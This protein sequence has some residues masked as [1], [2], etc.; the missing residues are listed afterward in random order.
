[1]KIISYTKKVTS[2][3]I[4]HIID[5]L[6]NRYKNLDVKIEVFGNRF[7]LWMYNFLKTRTTHNASVADFNEYHKSIRIYAHKEVEDKYLKLRVCYSLLHELR[8]KMQTIKFPTK[9]SIDN[10][11]YIPAGEGYSTQ[12]IEKD[13]NKFARRVMKLHK[14][15]ISKIYNLDEEWEFK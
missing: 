14:N 12:W 10:Q 5:L 13:A 2:K 11:N 9:Y 3:D 8:H 4:K 6:P 7:Y 15:K 1:M